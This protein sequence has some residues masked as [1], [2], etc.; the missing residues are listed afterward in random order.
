M[1]ALAALSS[2]HSPSDASYA[3]FRISRGV[4]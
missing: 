2:V 3:A 1:R 4:A